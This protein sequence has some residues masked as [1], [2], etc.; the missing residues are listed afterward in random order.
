MNDPQFVEAARGFAE[1]MIARADDPRKRIR[2]AFWEC[3]ARAPTAEEES[4]VVHL[5][6]QQRARFG[7]DRQ[8]A[9]AILAVGESPR[10]RSLDLVEHAAWSQ[11]ATVLLNMSETITRN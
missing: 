9:E 5:L 4:Q 10:D 3:L 11:V 6:A 1:R 2:W 7:A 8:A